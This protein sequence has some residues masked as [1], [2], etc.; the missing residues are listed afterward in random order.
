MAQSQAAPAQPVQASEPSSAQVATEKAS[1][2]KNI[3]PEGKKA[4]EEESETE[5]FRHSP[6]VQKFAGILHLPIETAA[7]LFEF[8]NF[9]ILAVSI[10]YFLF[11]LIPKAFRNRREAIEKQLVDA[12]SATEVA[13]ER[14]KGVEQKLSRLDQEIDEIRKKV[15]QDA[16]QDEARI[17]AALE[18][19]RL[20]IID[21]SGHEIEVAVSAAQREL[22]RFAAELAVQ[23]ATDQLS[24]NEETDRKLVQNFSRGLGN[25]H[26]GGR[27]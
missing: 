6:M 27:N 8:L 25:D 14:L 18:E 1:T 3:A 20:R 12:R 2:D 16:V 5:A 13:N 17:K 23:R 9:G 4:P 26:L 22:K 11:K 10:L 15:E 7:R 19:E 24:L 21:S